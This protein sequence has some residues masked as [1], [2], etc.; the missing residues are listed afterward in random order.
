MTSFVSGP[1]AGGTPISVIGTD[2]ADPTTMTIGG[3]SVPVTFGDDHTLQA[4]SPALD[5]GTVNDLV[6][7][8]PDGTTG[9]LD[10]GMGRRLPRRPGR[11]AVLLLRHDPGLQRDHRRRRRG[12]YGVD[13]PTLR[14]QMAVFLMKARH[15][16]CY[17][18]PPCTTQVFTDVPC[19]SNF[20][21]WINELVAEGITGGCGAGTYCP[22]DPVKRQ[23]MA[24]LLLQD[25]RGPRLHAPRLRHGDLR[26]RPLRQSV[27]AVD[28][29]ARRPQHHRR[30]RRRQLLPR[31]PRDPRTDGRLRRE[32]LQPPV[33]VL[34]HW[35]RGGRAATPDFSRPTLDSFLP[36]RHVALV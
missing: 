11:P 31:R 36:N 5:P 27:R 1:A 30:L 8:T 16:L 21:P 32:D 7:T 33:A 6:V 35:V 19:A 18:P 22:A 20:A 26:R 17:V 28:L 23:Q 14:Q 2:F 12:L 3:V 25:L 4:T 10:Q 13:Q 9:T 29:R 24:V 34:L 15:G